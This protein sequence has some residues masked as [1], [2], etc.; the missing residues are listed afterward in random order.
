MTSEPRTLFC[1]KRFEIVAVDQPGNDGEMHSR[2]IMRHPGAVVILP[3]VDEKHICLIR[4]LRVAV[5]ETLIELPAGTREPN[6]APELTAHREL[7]EETGYRA[8]RLELLT[9]FYPSPGVMNEK[10]FLYSAHGLT[11][12]E[13]AREVGEQIENLVVPIDEAYQMIERQEIQDGKTLVGLLL[14]A[15]KNGPI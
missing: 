14:W 12:G 8:A 4:N 11:A 5:N 10:M 13:H 9:T 7:Q 1:G 6:E 3:F 15:Q 2:E